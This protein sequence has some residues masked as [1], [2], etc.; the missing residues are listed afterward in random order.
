MVFFRT[1]KSI[2]LHINYLKNPFH[3][4]FARVPKIKQKQKDDP[5]DNSFLYWLLWLFGVKL[6]PTLDQVTILKEKFK[7]LYEEILDMKIA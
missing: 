6:F 5:S 7:A 1:Q 2:I 4:R 3:Y